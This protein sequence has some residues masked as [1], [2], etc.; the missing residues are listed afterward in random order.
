M[1]GVLHVVRKICR[2]FYN[3]LT[4]LATTLFETTQNSLS[5][6]SECVKVHR[7]WTDLLGKIGYLN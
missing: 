2:D 1:A 5:V 7:Q 6:S 4:L 3:D